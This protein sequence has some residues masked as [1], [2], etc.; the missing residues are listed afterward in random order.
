MSRESHVSPGRSGDPITGQRAT[1]GHRSELPGLQGRAMRKSLLI[2]NAMIGVLW[3][4]VCATH[5]IVWRLKR[6]KSVVQ[7]MISVSFTGN[8]GAPKKAK[9]VGKCAQKH[10]LSESSSEVSFPLCSSCG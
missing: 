8:C 1:G 10:R 6:A 3:K 4:A 9:S 2:P 7:Y 5:S